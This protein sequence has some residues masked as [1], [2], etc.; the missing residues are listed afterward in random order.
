MIESFYKYRI[1]G[2]IR[3]RKKNKFINYSLFNNYIINIQ[4]DIKQKEKNILDIGSGSGENTFFLARKNPQALIIAC[5]I[6]VDGNVNLVSKLHTEKINNVK[7]FS[8]NVIELFDKLKKD[9]YFTE[10]W[11]LFP[12]P[13][14]KNKHHKRRLIN[15]NFFNIIYPFLK[16]GGKIFIATDSV[17]YLHSIIKN[18]YQIRDIFS[19]QNDNSLNWI[20]D[21]HD[22]PN[23]KFFKKAQNSCRVPFFIELLK[24]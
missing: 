17:S 24:I 11:V 10:I 23:T 3:G 13:W 20:Y 15:Y 9:R 1:Y 14:P 21:R 2:R 12:D 6:F 18:V 7:L 16:E 22:L 8:S 5:E 19:W 4:N